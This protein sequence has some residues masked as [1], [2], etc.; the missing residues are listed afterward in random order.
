MPGPGAAH[1]N[2]AFR[3]DFRRHPQGVECVVDRFPIGLSV[4]T[5]KPSGARKTRDG[6]GALAQEFDGALFAKIAELAAPDADA[7]DARRLVSDDIFQKR[8][9]VGGHFIDRE[10]GHTW[11]S[12]CGCRTNLT[13]RIRHISLVSKRASAPATAR[14]NPT[15]QYRSGP[16]SKV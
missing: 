12:L 13:M 6:G 15:S 2:K 14:L 8:P 7:L 10:P 16:R 4:G 9:V 11:P 3:M 5:R 1:D